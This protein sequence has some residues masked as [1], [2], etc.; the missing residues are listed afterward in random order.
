MIEVRRDTYMNANTLARTA[1]AF[2]GIQQDI[3]GAIAGYCGTFKSN[4]TADA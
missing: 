2:E 1:G 3:R 4:V